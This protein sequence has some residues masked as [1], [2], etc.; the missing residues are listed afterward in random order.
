M[1][2]F[3]NP[4]DVQAIWLAELDGI[5]DEGGCFTLTCHPSIIG[6]HHRL[7]M[8]EAVVRHAKARGDVW[9]ATAQE[10]VAHVAGQ[11]S[12]DD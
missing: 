1:A 5:I 7:A 6:R 11:W 12:A 4:A 8:V 9:I 10:V 3:H 2:Q